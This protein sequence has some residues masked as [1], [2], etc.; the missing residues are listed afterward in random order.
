MMREP[1]RGARGPTVAG[2]DRRGLRGRDAEIEAIERLLNEVRTGSRA[3]VMTIVGDVGLGKSALLEHAIAAANGMRVLRCVGAPT[4]ATLPFAGLSQMLR[5]ILGLIGQLPGPQAAAL[6]SVFGLSEDQ[7]EDRFLI[8]VGVLSLLS[9]AAEQVPLLCAVDEVRW[10]D[11]ESADVLAFVARRIQAEPIAFVVALAAEDALR[12]TVPDPRRVLLS[13]LA[14]GDARAVV[15]DVTPAGVS[16]SVVDRIVRTADGVPLLLT[17]LVSSLTPD[18]LEGRAPL[19]DA[20][21]VSPDVEALYLGRVRALPASSQT[22][23]LVAELVGS[24]A[25]L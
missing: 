19:P 10:L 6:R 12:F 5:P 4:E 22:A 17:E 13:T 15:R 2:S 23:L 7:V 25:R 16:P 1:A 20:L 14:E 11:H 9:E 8:S 18:Q 24:G 21:P 3:G